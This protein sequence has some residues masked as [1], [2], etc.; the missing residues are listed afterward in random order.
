MS[1]LELRNEGAAGE[2]H[3]VDGRP[4]HCGDGLELRLTEGRWERVR[5]ELAWE[6]R[7]QRNAPVLHMAVGGVWEAWTPP[8]GRRAWD[9]VQTRC[10][11]CDGKGVTET[12]SCEWCDRKGWR[13]TVIQPPGPVQVEIR[14]L[15]Q[16]ELRWP[17]E[18]P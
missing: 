7:R 15:D 16:V 13:W 12:G 8:P 6:P 9:D 14:N 11:D 5:F 18:R 4:V 2:R 3:Y 10:E 17:K 1:R